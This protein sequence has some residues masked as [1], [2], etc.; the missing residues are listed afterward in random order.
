[1]WLIP[2]C[3]KYLSDLFLLWYVRL[4]RLGILFKYRK[5][6]GQDKAN[7]RQKGTGANLAQSDEFVELEGGRGGAH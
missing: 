2:D 6:E 1:M 4:Y 5:G 3:A 7:R